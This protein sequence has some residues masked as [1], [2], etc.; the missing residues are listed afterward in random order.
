MRTRCVESHRRRSNM[1]KISSVNR[2]LLE[3][4][5]PMSDAKEIN[6][7]EI[8]E[9]K[10]DRIRK[11]SITWGTFWRHRLTFS[12]LNKRTRIITQ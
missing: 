7:V 12:H 8:N 9:K 2:I 11:G 1:L 3:L 6:N 10:R 4:T 5:F